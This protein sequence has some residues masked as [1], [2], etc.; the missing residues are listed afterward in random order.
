[1]TDDQEK[2]IFTDDFF[3][4]LRNSQRRDTRALAESYKNVLRLMAY[5]K[6]ISRVKVLDL[7][8]NLMIS[9]SPLR[10][11]YVRRIRGLAKD[12]RGENITARMIGSEIV[13]D[14]KDLAFVQRLL[15]VVKSDLQM[16]LVTRLDYELAKCN[17]P[18]E[19]PPFKSTPLKK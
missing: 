8:K 17:L 10:D 15:A 6:N 4:R 13:G 3:D 5:R 2:V 9:Q 12:I 1:M 7:Y 16:A 14:G 11:K 19:I 18:P